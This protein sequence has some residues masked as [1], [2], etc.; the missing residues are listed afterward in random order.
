MHPST[1]AIGIVTNPN[2]RK[3]RAGRRLETL[4]ALVGDLGVVYETRTVAELPAVATELWRSGVRTWVSDGGDGTFH[5]LL[6]AAA[7]TAP[8]GLSERGP[9]FL[10]T[11]GGTVDFVAKKA[12]L[13][14]SA[15][16]TVRALVA[17]VR[18]GREP[19]R[20][21]LDTLELVGWR[22]AQPEV[23]W[24][25]FGFA[26]ALG[27]VGQR[28]FAKYYEDPRQG[29][30]GAL[31]VILKGMVGIGH[32]APLLGRLIPPHLGAHAEHLIRPT[33]AQVTIDERV[34]PTT[35]L[36]GLH[37]GSIDVDVGVARLFPYARE[38]GHMHV[39]VGSMTPAE[40]AVKWMVLAM[41]RPASGPNWHEQAARSL[42]VEGRGESLDPVVDGELY[43]GF[44]RLEVRLG[45]AVSVVQLHG[46]A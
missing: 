46:A 27:G 36:H 9:A 20:V 25:R 40:I 15:D 11:T 17:L 2:A 23:P 42:L 24:R 37:V 21:R 34:V 31:R 8:D 33:P 3:N 4:R 22:N 14:G 1:P 43:F 19:T 35:A 29:V 13:R 16:G 41:G 6:N 32:R 10:P 28:F 38:P 39:A 12:G 7:S 26:A 44:D 45:P 30:A 18:G 5:A